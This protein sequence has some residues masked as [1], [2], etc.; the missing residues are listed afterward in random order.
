MRHVL[1][2]N[3][4]FSNADYWDFVVESSINVL[5]EARLDPNR[6]SSGCAVLLIGFRE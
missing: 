6:I 4:Q 5:V 1:F 3:S 2:S